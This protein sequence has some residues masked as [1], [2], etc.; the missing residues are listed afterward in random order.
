MEGTLFDKLSK[1]GAVRGV[2]T[3]TSM[4]ADARA[5]DDLIHWGSLDTYRPDG[6]FTAILFLDVLEHVAAPADALRRAFELLEP[7]GL[8]FAT[9]PAFPVLWTRH[10]ELN[11]HLIRYTRESFSNSVAEAGGR[12]VRMGYFFHWV[13]PLKLCV[14]LMEHLN[15]ERR[16]AATIPRV[17]PK[18]VNRFFYWL[19]RLEQMIHA[20]RI[21]PLEVP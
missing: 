17:P 3:D 2:E 1:L 11:H 5:V 4:R 13:F 21:L 7:G 15:S 18:P 14:R 6:L 16:K 19:S 12:V 8:I 20:E 9:V 10:D